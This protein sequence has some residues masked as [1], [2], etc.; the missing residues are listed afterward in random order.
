MPNQASV[1]HLV[2]VGQQVLGEGAH[3]GHQG[4]TEDHVTTQLDLRVCTGGDGSMKKIK[5][6]R[7]TQDWDEVHKDTVT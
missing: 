5:T 1:T 2:E 4:L 3:S 7:T 6:P